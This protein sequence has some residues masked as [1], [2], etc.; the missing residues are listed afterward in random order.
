MCGCRLHECVKQLVKENIQMQRRERAELEERQRAE[1]DL[2]R[3][4]IK[5]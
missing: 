5:K 3:S 4:Y 2:H 1:L